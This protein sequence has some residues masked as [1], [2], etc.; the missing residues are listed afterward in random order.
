MKQISK[1]FLICT[2]LTSYLF[3]YSQYYP[4]ENEEI[5]KLKSDY[6]CPQ[7]TKEQ[8]Y[9]DFDY[10]V[11]I[12]RNCNPKYSVIKVN[13]GYD[14][15]EQLLPFRDKIENVKTTFEFIHLM[16]TAMN[17]VLGGHGG[18]GL[19]L[20]YSRNG[21]YKEEVKLLELTNQD[22]AC[23]FHYYNEESW[24][25]PPFLN[26]C[27]SNGK[28]CLKNSTTFYCNGDTIQIPIGSEVILYNNQSVAEYI[29]DSARTS[30]SCWDNDRKKFYARR[31]DIKD[32]WTKIRFLVDNKPVDVNFSHFKEYEKGFDRDRNSKM[33]IHYFQHDSL[34][35]IRLPLTFS[36]TFKMAEKILPYKQYPFKTVMVDIREHY[37]GKD[38]VWKFL[39]SLIGGDTFRSH[40]SLIANDDPEV[41]KRYPEC[42]TQKSWPMLNAEQPFI[43]IED[44]QIEIE[45]AQENLGYTGTIYILVDDRVRSSAEGFT[46][47]N[48]QNERIKT[49]GIP[50]GVYHGRGV[51]LTVFI[52]PNSRFCFTLNITLDD[53]NIAAPIDFLHDY[54]SYPIF[55][56]L[57]YF[58]YYHSPQRPN[59]IDE[60]AMYEHDELFVKALEIIK[61]KK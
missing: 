52:L 61:A 38:K 23:M 50:T 46:S 7:L 49:I 21:F 32:E 41:R 35:Y 25:H 28:Y 36:D 1:L 4:P 47:L 39:L 30:A 37:G 18:I 51:T 6:P 13:T 2:F 33:Y 17:N 31:I 54:V 11:K 22:F 58:K 42:N 56:S 8:M 10:F 20:W 59:E 48:K 27:Y 45:N 34:L 9:E 15:I 40:S 55:P 43:V 44:E 3:V 14:M 12:I 26:F 5:K 57:N 24:R 16:K 60:K 53:A 29:H 19:D